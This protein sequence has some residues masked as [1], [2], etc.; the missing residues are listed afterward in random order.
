MS[1]VQTPESRPSRPIKNTYGKKAQVAS[2]DID[3]ENQ[4][5]NNNTA[6]SFSTLADGDDFFGDLDASKSM[7]E[8]R[9]KHDSSKET[10][11]H[12]NLVE[13]QLIS[14]ENPCLDSMSKLETHLKVFD[15]QFTQKQPSSIGFDLI[16]EDSEDDK[17][18]TDEAFMNRFR[19]QLLTKLKGDIEPS[20]S[21]SPVNKTSSPVTTTQ[22][23]RP[24]LAD[25]SDDERDL[26]LSPPSSP[27]VEAAEEETSVE[28]I[29]QNLSDNEERDETLETPKSK[30][31][32]KKVRLSRF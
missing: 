30:S 19:S 20:S 15:Q 8:Q 16:G 1:S 3:K 7:F 9:N 29:T 18:E 17:E 5:E 11:S 25:L 10:Q 12:E 23:I 22:P 4:I 32:S 6:F 28:P 14:A 13:T 24:T 27:V 21:A 31:K 26:F 2:H